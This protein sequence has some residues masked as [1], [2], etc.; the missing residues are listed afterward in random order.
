MAIQATRGLHPFI[1]IAP[2]NITGVVRPNYTGRWIVM[3][4]WVGDVFASEWNQL[5]TEAQTE[6]AA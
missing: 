6:K 2:P 4:L 1:V 3:A 5:A